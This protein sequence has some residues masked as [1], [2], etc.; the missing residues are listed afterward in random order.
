M[1]AVALPLAGGPIAFTSVVA[2]EGDRSNSRRRLF[3]VE[4]LL[5]SRDGDLGTAVPSTSK[6]EG[7][8]DGS[9]EKKDDHDADGKE[10][11]K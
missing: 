3:S 4:W 9:D 2:I 6:G 7:A 1:V 11:S 8:E 5:E 10:D